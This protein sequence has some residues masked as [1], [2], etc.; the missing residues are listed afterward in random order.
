MSVL[1]ISVDIP[2]MVAATVAGDLDPKANDRQSIVRIARLLEQI[3]GGV[4]PAKLYLNTGAVPAAGT[5]VF[6]SFAADGT[7]TINGNVL[8]G[9]A[10]PSGANQFA[11][12]STDQDVSNNLV[13]KVNTSTL[14]K[15]VGVVHASRRGS[16]ALSS[17]VATNTVTINGVVFTGSATPTGPNQFLIGAD[18]SAT[19]QYLLDAILA[20]SDTRVA[21]IAGSRSTATLT[22]NYD[23]SLTLAVSANGTAT[24]TTVVLTSIVGG[25]IGNLMTLAISANGTKVDPTGGTEGTQTLFTAIG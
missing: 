13:A 18:N 1:R 21:G 23:G 14:A 17:F 12:G 20:N 10:S 11:V 25:Q 15:I 9:K 3:A 6:A 19:A 22:L 16:I 4:T 2:T 5:Y 24:S 7:V 8:T